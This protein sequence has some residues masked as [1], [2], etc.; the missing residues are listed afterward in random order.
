MLSL[1]PAGSVTEAVCED[2]PGDLDPKA[3]PITL[4]EPYKWVIIEEEYPCSVTKLHS[5]IFEKG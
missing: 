2:D 4:P 1:V 3:T 5:T